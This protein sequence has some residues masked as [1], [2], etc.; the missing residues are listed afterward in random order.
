MST[1]TPRRW[2]VLL[3]FAFPLS[4][5]AQTRSWFRQ[6]IPAGSVLHLQDF[7]GSDIDLTVKGREMSAIYIQWSDNTKKVRKFVTDIN[8]VT[9]P[10]FVS[11]TY[12]RTIKKEKGIPVDGRISEAYLIYTDVPS[13]LKVYFYDA[14]TSENQYAL[15]IEPAPTTSPTAAPPVPA[16]LDEA[17]IGHLI[18]SLTDPTKVVALDVGTREISGHYQKLI[19]WLAV[20]TSSGFDAEQ[21]LRTALQ[22]NGTDPARAALAVE[23]V[24]ECFDHSLKEQW[25]S[26]EN[27]DRMRSGQPGLVFKSGRGEEPV[28]VDHIIPVAVRPEFANELANLRLRLASASAAKGTRL[29]ADSTNLLTRLESLPAVPQLPPIGEQLIEPRGVRPPVAMPAPAFSDPASPPTWSLIGDTLFYRGNAVTEQVSADAAKLGL[30]TEVFVEE[31]IWIEKQRLYGA[32][33]GAEYDAI[34]EERMSGR[35]PAEQSAIERLRAT[36]LH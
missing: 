13:G 27:L 20:A 21:I 25:L 9:S 10:V 16:V 32:R 14:I 17:S 26:S 1:V 7:G 31:R 29:D 19:Y 22:H 18:E 24:L 36:L 2:L 15:L 33:Q 6:D 30:S 28:V 3:A 11:P 12:G 5:W 35:S 4:G 8:G 23:M 34:T